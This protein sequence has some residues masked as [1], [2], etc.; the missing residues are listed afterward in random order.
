[1]D[2]VENAQV[3]LGPWVLEG[4]GEV[5]DAICILWEQLAFNVATIVFML[6]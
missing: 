5:G 2:K 3:L 6:G 4:M 1:V